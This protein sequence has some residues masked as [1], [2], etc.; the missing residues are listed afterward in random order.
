MICTIKTPDSKD[1]ICIHLQ[2]IFTKTNDG[3]KELTND[4]QELRMGKERV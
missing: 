3:A 1:Y 2:G 4:Y